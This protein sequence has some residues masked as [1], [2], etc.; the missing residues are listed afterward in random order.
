MH[1]FE[2]RIGRLSGATAALLLALT[3]SAHAHVTLTSPNGGEA[4][5]PGSTVTI[6]WKIQISHNLQNWD[7][8]YS[9]TGSGPWTPIATNLAPGSSAAGS[10]HSFDW[11]VPATASNTVKVRVRM[12]NSG[13]DYFDVSN[14]VFSILSLGGDTSSLSLSAG[15]AQNLALGTDASQSGM[16]YMMLGSATGTAPGVPA[17]ALVLPLV[18]DGYFQFTLAHPNTLV[19]GSLGLLDA[20]GQASAVLAIPPGLD[21]GLAGLTLYHAYAV[22]DVFGSFQT[23][24][25]SNPVSVTF[26]P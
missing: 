10:V 4:L 7:L 8:W 21:P 25:A 22:I 5:E 6:Q 15:G 14:N 18:P 19:L 2:S 20:A 23:V 16:L 1:V 24:H 3:G 17:G 26:T 9:T 12:D 13:A 11:V